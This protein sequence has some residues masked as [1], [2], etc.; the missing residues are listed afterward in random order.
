[1]GKYAAYVLWAY[2][3]SVL[4]IGVMILDTVLRA[5]RWRAEVQRREQAPDKGG[6]E[7]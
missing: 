2:A 6:G 7:T 4:V 3:I 1:M 5:R